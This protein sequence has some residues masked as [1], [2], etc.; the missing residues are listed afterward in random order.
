LD[1]RQ[2]SEGIGEDPS[3]YFLLHALKS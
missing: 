2:S 3:V 1:E